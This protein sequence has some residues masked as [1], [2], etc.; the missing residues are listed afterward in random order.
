MLCHPS[1]INDSLAL[2][3]ENKD[4]YS[5][6]LIYAIF[7]LVYVNELEAFTSQ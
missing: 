4:E 7:A 6:Y 2:L 5:E 1:L 3:A